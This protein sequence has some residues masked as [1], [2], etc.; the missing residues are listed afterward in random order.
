MNDVKHV[1]FVFKRRGHDSACC[2]PRSR[3][4]KKFLWRIYRHKY[5]DF[6]KI[7]WRFW[8]IL[9]KIIIL[10]VSYGKVSTTNNF[11]LRLF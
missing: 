11:R 8:L 5:A 10:H 3:F 7:W 4:S 1:L 6:R 9:I 2:E